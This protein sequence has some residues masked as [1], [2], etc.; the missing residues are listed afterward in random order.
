MMSTIRTLT[1][2]AD[3]VRRGD[4]IPLRGVVGIVTDVIV[5][6]GNLPRVDVTVDAGMAGTVRDV[7]AP[8]RPIVAE[9]NAY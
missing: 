8:D 5:Y 1:I 9:R 7:F 3:E 2:R 4:V 6:G